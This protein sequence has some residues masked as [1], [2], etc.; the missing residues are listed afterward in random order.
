MENFCLAELKKEYE[1]LRSKYNLPGFEEMN[2]NFEIEKLQERETETLIREVRRMMVEKSI[3]YL[4]FVEMF[5]N[6]SQAPMFFFALVKGL[7]NDERKILDE[8]YIGLGKF[9]ISSLALDNDYDAGKESEF[10]KK[11]YNAWGDIREKFGKVIKA[12]EESWEKKSERKEK[13]YLG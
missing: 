10:I 8:L 9:E 13:G 2:N 4:K 11:F 6:P 3:A 7:D 1:K 12:L 5:M